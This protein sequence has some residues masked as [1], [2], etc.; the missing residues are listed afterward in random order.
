MEY[1]VPFS[2]FSSLPDLLRHLLR[3]A[4]SDDHPLW[5]HFDMARAKTGAEPYRSFVA[6]VDGTDD[7]SQTSEKRI[8]AVVAKLSVPDKTDAKV[9][10]VA[11]FLLLANEIL[12]APAAS[13]VKRKV[14]V[15]CLG[16]AKL[17]VLTALVLDIPCTLMATETH[18]YAVLADGTRLDFE[19]N[20]QS[21]TKLVKQGLHSALYQSPVAL[22][23][24]DVIATT[25]LNDETPDDDVE[26]CLVLLY[27]G[28]DMERAPIWV[29]AFMHGRGHD[30][31]IPDAHKHPYS[32]LDM[33]KE[34][35]DVAKLRNALE[36]LTCGKWQHDLELFFR[37]ETD[38]TTVEARPDG[39]QGSKL[40]FASVAK[41]KSH[42][43]TKERRITE[44]DIKT[45]IKSKRVIADPK[46]PSHRYVLEYAPTE[47]S[48]L[49]V[50]EH[51]RCHMNRTFG[52][53]LAAPQIRS[54]TK[55]KAGELSDVADLVQKRAVECLSESDAA[56]VAKQCQ[57]FKKRLLKQPRDKD[58]TSIPDCD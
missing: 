2:K 42:F 37:K 46:S 58:D 10:S 17:A 53:N 45:F 9:K 41:A 13:P 40:T 25:L 22:S 50:L 12:R 29:R 3:H 52:K 36:A 21:D 28:R 16:R 24:R 18:T 20:L 8:G 49:N 48:F 31:D 32:S 14:K 43:S 30:F 39:R 33:A 23:S 56:V 1:R 5:V 55:R 44:D 15:E 26:A 57:T 19:G 4:K 7:D 38:I 35:L 34:R 47:V 27:P 6:L 51:L 54:A 11:P